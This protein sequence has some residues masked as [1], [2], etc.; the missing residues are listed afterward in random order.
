MEKR[1]LDD[2]IALSCI[3][4][5][6]FY[7]RE[8]LLQVLKSRLRSDLAHVNLDFFPEWTRNRFLSVTIDH[9]VRRG[10]KR[11]IKCDFLNMC[12]FGSVTIYT[13]RDR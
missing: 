6:L 12:L 10:I 13:D 5:C 3:V 11:Q 9:A 2:D 8:V 7:V 4:L 1:G